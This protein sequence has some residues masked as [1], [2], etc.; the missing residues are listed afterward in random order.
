MA[1][2][3]GIFGILGRFAGRL[4]NA[5]LGWA[6]ILL[7]GK[8]SGPKQTVVLLIALASIVWVVLVVGVIVPDVMSRADIYDSI[9]RIAEDGCAVLVASSDLAEIHALCDR[10]LVLSRGKII[11]QGP[12]RR[13]RQGPD[14]G[15]PGCEVVRHPSLPLKKKSV[16]A[17]RSGF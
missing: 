11:A 8:V 16:D 3:S 14:S 15:H 17:R 6:T 2:L 10:T 13:L 7:F 4:L 12:P 5:I 1:I 9:R